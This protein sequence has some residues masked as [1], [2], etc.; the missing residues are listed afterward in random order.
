M[1]H[2]ILLTTFASILSVG[3][4]DEQQS[5][6]PQGSNASKQSY[7]VDYEELYAKGTPDGEITTIHNKEDQR[8]SGIMDSLRTA[9]KM[10][11]WSYSSGAFQSSSRARG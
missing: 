6:K 10:L 11:K 5:Q 9:L 4:M 2:Y 3:A 7:V 8:L 1:M